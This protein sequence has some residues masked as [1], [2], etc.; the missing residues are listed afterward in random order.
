[1]RERDHY[2]RLNLLFSNTNPC[3]KLETKQNVSFSSLLLLPLAIGNEIYFS[4]NLNKFIISKLVKVKGYCSLAFDF[5]FKF[6]N[7]KVAFF[8]VDY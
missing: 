2:Y 1:M 6:C 5:Y 4:I 3:R 8:L 7:F